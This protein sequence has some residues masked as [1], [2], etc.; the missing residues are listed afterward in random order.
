MLADL[1]PE[2]SQPDTDKEKVRRGLS[3]EDGGQ[4]LPGLMAPCISS[5]LVVGA[6]T[7]QGHLAVVE[8]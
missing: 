1:H 3:R 8:G 7:F 2:D 5:P 4:L 6:V